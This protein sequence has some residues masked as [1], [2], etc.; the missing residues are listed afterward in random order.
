MKRIR[1]HA[2]ALL[3]VSMSWCLAVLAGCQAIGWSTQPTDELPPDKQALDRIAA[4]H[5]R[6]GATRDKVTDPGRPVVDQPD[7]PPLTGLLGNVQAPI[8][9]EIFTPVNAWAGWVDETTYVQVWA[10]VSPSKPGRGYVFVGRHTGAHG[11]I[12]HD[13][14]PTTSLV[15]APAG[16]LPLKILRVDGDILIL[17]TPDGLEFRFDPASATFDR[18]GS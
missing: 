11:V 17:V 13:V 4:E 15:A 14:E 12:D 2:I 8:F 5:Q 16:G 9:G 10:G 1:R 7:P 6:A 3:A 18:S